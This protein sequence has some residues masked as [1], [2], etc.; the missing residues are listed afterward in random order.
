MAESTDMVVVSV[1]PRDTKLA[2][3]TIR[4]AVPGTQRLVG[5]DKGPMVEIY[6]VSHYGR[7]S[8]SVEQIEAVAREKLA[9]FV[10]NAI[11]TGDWSTGQ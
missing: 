5:R 10:A 3:A 7:D 4:I 8:D 6:G 9:D 2:I 11:R 1:S